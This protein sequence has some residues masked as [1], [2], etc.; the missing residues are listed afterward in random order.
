MCKEGGIG[1]AVLWG[2]SRSQEVGRSGAVLDLLF[3]CGHVG[4][5]D[6]GRQIL[7]LIVFVQ[8]GV[9]GFFRRQEVKVVGAELLDAFLVVEAAFFWTRALLMRVVMLVPFSATVVAK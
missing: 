7:E 6:R 2:R 3:Q 4:D 5:Q 9:V 1:F 8:K